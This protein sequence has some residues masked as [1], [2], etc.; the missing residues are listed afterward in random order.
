MKSH[1]LS[2][3]QVLLL[4]KIKISTIAPPNQLN[5]KSVMFSRVIFS[6]SKKE[7]LA[8][9]RVLKNVLVV[10]R[11]CLHYTVLVRTLHFIKQQQQQQQ[12]RR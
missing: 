9:C 8:V 5:K 10:R 1:P 7:W 4:L 6:N 12:T 11:L 2:T 3:C